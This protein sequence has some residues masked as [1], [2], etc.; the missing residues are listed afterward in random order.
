MTRTGTTLLYTCLLF[1]TLASGATAAAE[2]T[3]SVADPYL[4]LR[5]GPGRGYPVFHVVAR[6]AAVTIDKRRTDWFK[7]EARRGKSGWV[8]RDQLLATLAPDGQHLE[9]D[10]PNRAHF[11]SRRWEGSAMAGDFGGASV[12]GVVGGYALNPS[13]TLE[14]GVSHAI[15]DFSDSWFATASIVH[16]FEPAWRYSPIVSLGTGVIS[17]DP[18][19]TLVQAE[20]RT[21]QLAVVGIGVRGYLTRR[22]MVR[23]EYKSYVV[24]TS[25]DD[26]EEVDEWKAGFAFFF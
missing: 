21:D 13:F 3:V 23:A 5:T 11:A 14:L 17:T 10:E 7:V 22:F 19:S 25:R 2:I 24:F 12:I 15:G 18:K 4:E 1:A 16:V 26:N 8:H 9:L 6:G 20:D